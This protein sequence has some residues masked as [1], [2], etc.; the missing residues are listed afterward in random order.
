MKYIFFLLLLL[1]I[2]CSSGP[3]RLN[4]LTKHGIFFQKENTSINITGT[5]GVK[6]MVQYTGSGGLYFLKDGLGILVDPFFSHQRVMKI[7]TSVLGGGVRGKRKLASDPAM[8]NLGLKSMESAGQKQPLEISAIFSAHSHYDHLMDVP[9]IFNKLNKTPIVYVNQSGFNT[10]YNVIDTAQMVILEN[11]MTTREVR[12][13]PIEILTQESK[14]HIYPI[15]S[16][17]NPHFKSIKFFS[18]RNTKPILDFNDVY[19]KTYANDWL[20]GNTFSFLID[21]LDANGKVEFRIFVQSSSCSPPAGIPPQALLQDKEVDLAFLGVVS[22]HFSPDYPCTLLNA[23]KPK[24]VVWVHWEDFF[25]KYTKDP[26]TVRGTDVA[27]FFELP[28]V[29]PYRSKGFLP[30]P[31]VKFEIQ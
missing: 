14:V 26:K 24:Q 17:H 8:I 30:L 2:G 20:E 15:L 28:C 27:K 22:Y 13:P 23:I 29:Q 3:G 16:E 21:Y 9:A 4:K 18:G 5:P 25:R 7:G 19:G 1:M 6:L 11:H 12:R 31:G 10:C